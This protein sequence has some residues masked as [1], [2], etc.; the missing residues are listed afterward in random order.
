MTTVR[1][2]D[3]K[4]GYLGLH[5]INLNFVISKE[6]GTFL[7]ETKNVTRLRNRRNNGKSCQ[8]EKGLIEH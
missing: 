5:G 1:T 8:L 3:L 6:K 7:L 2:N 4:S